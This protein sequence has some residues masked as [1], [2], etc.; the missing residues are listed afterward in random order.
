MTE[1]LENDIT[2]SGIYAI[3]IKKNLI[4]NKLSIANQ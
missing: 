2:Q 1:T 4:Q 3:E